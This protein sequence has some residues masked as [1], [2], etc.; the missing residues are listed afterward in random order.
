MFPTTM[1]PVTTDPTTTIPTTYAPTTSIINPTHSPTHSPISD[2]II[3]ERTTMN[4][5]LMNGNLNTESNGYDFID[6][7][8]IVTI[9]VV[10]IALICVIIILY[11]IRKSKVNNIKIEINEMT[12]TANVSRVLSVSDDGLK[13]VN[14]SDVIAIINETDIGNDYEVIGTDQIKQTNGMLAMDAQIKNNKDTDIDKDIDV[15]FIDPINATDDGRNKIHENM[16]ELN[17]END[18]TVEGS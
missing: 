12:E 3:H 4:T 6:L 17:G 1:F 14:D 18:Q 7:V 5:I 9:I 13:K 2:G 11:R 8:I 10:L 16:T 15:D